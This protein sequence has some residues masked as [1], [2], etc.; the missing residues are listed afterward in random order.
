MNTEIVAE[1]A[2]ELY[3]LADLGDEMEATDFDAVEYPF[4][5]VPRPPVPGK[6]GWSSTAW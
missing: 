1:T 6:T 3:E 5:I 2:A 4:Y